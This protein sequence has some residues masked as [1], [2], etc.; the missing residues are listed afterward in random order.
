MD[1]NNKELNGFL[2]FDIVFEGQ[3]L[4][5]DQGIGNYQEL[6]KIHE[7]GNIYTLVS[8]YALRYSILEQ[9]S[10]KFGWKLADR[11]VLTTAGVGNRK[12]IQPS[13][14][15]LDS[16]LNY[17]DLNLFGFLITNFAGDYSLSRPSPVRLSHAVSLEPYK[18]DSHFN[19]NLGVAKRY[20]S[21][22]QNIFQVEEHKSYYKYNV[23]VD[24]AKISKMEIFL[25]KEEIDGD[26]FNKLKELCEKEKDNIRLKE[27]GNN[28]YKLIIIS[29]DKNSSPDKLII[30]LV[31]ILLSLKRNIKGRSENLEPVFMVVAYYKNFYDT[32]LE[33]I[34]LKTNKVRETEIEEEHK[35]EKTIIKRVREK[36]FDTVSFDLMRLPP[37]TTC[38]YL[39][40]AKSEN[41]IDKELSKK[42]EDN[43]DEVITYNKDKVIT[44]IKE[45]LGLEKN[46]N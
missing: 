15:K 30:Q 16:L 19:V 13:K 2:V 46:K 24:L 17:V 25:N 4:N 36:N 5:Y 45:W 1:N 40:Y 38:N 22:D 42:L 7:R 35:D 33:D 9:G 26:T 29:S 34:L 18:F 10:T 23:I 28:V 39:I 21:L 14:D 12:V 20:G 6:K 44:K 32:F 8:R 43:K 27:E 41:F 3:S 11:T 37:E 31:D